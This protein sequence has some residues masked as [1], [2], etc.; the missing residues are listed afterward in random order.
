MEMMETGKDMM[1]PSMEKAT[2]GICLRKPTTWEVM[3]MLS[4][5]RSV[6]S[7]SISMKMPSQPTWM[8]GDTWLRSRPVVATARWWHWQTPQSHLH[9][10]ATSFLL[11][12]RSRQGQGQAWERK[13][14]ILERITTEGFSWSPCRSHEVWYA[15]TLGRPMPSKCFESNI[16]QAQPFYHTWQLSQEGPH[17]WQ[18]HD[19]ER[20]GQAEYSGM[21][22]LWTF[23]MV[24]NSRWWSLFGG[25]W[26]Q[27]TIDKDSVAAVC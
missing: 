9:Q 2:I 13:R 10:L 8:P 19:G 23:R 3:R 12:E 20:Y 17:R 15:R 24:W 27:H 7:W 21:P 1:R 14:K 5:R 26:P 6:P 4:M 11:T 25:D 22:R 18:C 16:Y